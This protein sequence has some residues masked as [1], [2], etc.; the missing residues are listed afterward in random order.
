MHDTTIDGQRGEAIRSNMN[1]DTLMK[2]TGF[3]R[4]E[5]T[6]GLQPAISEFLNAHSEWKTHDVFTHN[7]GLTI[8]K[9]YI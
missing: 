3:S 9:K 8:L 1:I 7:N 5:L 6:S 2:N 4:D